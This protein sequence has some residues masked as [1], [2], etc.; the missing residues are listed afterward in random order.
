MQD[1]DA[2][3]CSAAVVGQ[4]VRAGDKFCGV[5]HKPDV[6]T[7]LSHGTTVPSG[8]QIAL[9]GR[10]NAGP[11]ICGTGIYSFAATGA[12]EQA[13]LARSWA[14]TQSGGYNTGCLWVLKREGFRGIVFARVKHGG[15]IL[16]NV[17]LCVLAQRAHA[18]HTPRS[19]D[20]STH[21]SCP[22]F[23]FLQV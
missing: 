2:L 17:G 12:I 13:D 18:K 21:V 14:R 20:S 1:V 16:R 15:A 22:G 23:R 11:G 5:S 6:P 8:L 10:I 3:A 4:G 9:D 7:F 19:R